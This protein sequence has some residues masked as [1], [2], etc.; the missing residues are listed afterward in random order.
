MDEYLAYLAL[1]LLYDAALAAG[2]SYAIWR[3]ATP[4]RIG[5]AVMIS[6]SVLSVIAARGS[7][8]LVGRT[9][10]MIVDGL[11]LVAFL[12]LV[13]KSNRFW[14]IWVS[15]LQ[16]IAVATH[17]AM[18]ISPSPAVSADWPQLRPLLQAYAIA[19]GFWAYPMLGLIVFAAYR[20][21]RLHRRASPLSKSRD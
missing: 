16:L 1:R 13:L 4:E 8:W 15:A 14:P 9:G 7:Q 3:G 21:H 12:V 10:L 11:V 20:Q 5:V 2:C 17:I 6:G 18:A 19:Q